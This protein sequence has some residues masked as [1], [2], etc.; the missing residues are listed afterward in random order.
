VF[1][2]LHRISFFRGID[3]NCGQD[4]ASSTDEHDGASAWLQGDE[5]A[6]ELEGAICRDDG[7]TM[8]NKS[9]LA[10]LLMLDTYCW[11]NIMAACSAC[12]GAQVQ[13]MVQHV[14]EAQVEHAHQDATAQ[15][16]LQGW[17]ARSC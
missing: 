5:H 14:G 1:K 17:V 12:Q 13:Q 3:T 11:T 4:V 10:G 2:H 7:R 6:R 16:C 15:W 8:L 9:M